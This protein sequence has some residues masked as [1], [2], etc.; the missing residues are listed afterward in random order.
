MQNKSDRF[1]YRLDIC[2][3]ICAIAISAWTIR[4]TWPHRGEIVL[5]NGLD[6]ADILITL[7]DM[8]GVASLCTLILLAL[9]LVIERERTR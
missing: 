9:A 1:F 5:K 7:C 4:F 8:A 3:G 2:A 6:L